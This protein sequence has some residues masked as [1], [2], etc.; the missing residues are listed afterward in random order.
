VCPTY[1]NDMRWVGNVPEG[2]KDSYHI[3]YDNPEGDQ[4]A[5]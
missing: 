5:G 2:T 3:N 1:S 4:M